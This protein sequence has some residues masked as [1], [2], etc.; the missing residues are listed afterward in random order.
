MSKTSAAQRVVELILA[1]SE[2]GS[3]GAE[4]SVSEYEDN[5][6]TDSDS[7]AEFEDEVCSEP[8]PEGTAQPN[9]GGATQPMIE[10]GLGGAQH[11]LSV[12]PRRT[13][14]NGFQSW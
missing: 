11:T 5:V 2:T 13:R 8:P 1:D 3:E 6:E 14:L 4:D 12:Y 9:A 10:G 7:N